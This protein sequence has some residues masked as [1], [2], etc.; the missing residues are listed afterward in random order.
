MTI[1]ASQPASIGPSLTPNLELRSENAG[2]PPPCRYQPRD[3]RASGSES[4]SEPSMRGSAAQR[5]KDQATKRP[6]QILAA[7]LERPGEVVTWEEIS[8]LW[9]PIPLLTLNTALILR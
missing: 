9:P 8:K 3:L 7:L 6:F 2:E 4:S 1:V 5:R